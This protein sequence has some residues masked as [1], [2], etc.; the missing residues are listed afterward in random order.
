VEF[1]SAPAALLIAGFGCWR[2]RGAGP[3]RG[4]RLLS[5]ALM[6]GAAAAVPFAVY[7]VLAFGSVAHI[8]YSEGM[9]YIGMRSGL[10]GVSLPR[11]DVAGELLF[12]TRRG[13]LW[14][15]PLLLVVPVAWPLAVRRFGLAMALPLIGVPIVFFLINAGYFY[16]DGGASTGPRHLMPMLPF[17]A[18]TLAP[19]WEWA[20]RPV[21]VV[22]GALAAFSAALSFMCAT[23]IMTTPNL[24]DNK[25]IQDE[26]FD[27]VLPAFRGG[28]VH[29]IWAPL[30][31]GGTASVAILVVPVM[32]GILLSGVA[33]RIRR[34]NAS[35]ASA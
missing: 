10:F 29:N 25:R 33:P 32:A 8:G 12:G 34:R 23:T 2:L 27:F 1:P 9:G 17:L 26:L 16:W 14:I 15:A 11:G 24:L 35:A 5:A 30:G 4:G 21:R 20:D 31:A 13:I 18:F 28:Q 19:L 7:N 22:L 3:S 6:G